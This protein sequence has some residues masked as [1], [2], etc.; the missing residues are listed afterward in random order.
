MY[1]VFRKFH[2]LFIVSMTENYSNLNPERGSNAI[3]FILGPFRFENCLEAPKFIKAFLVG[4]F[5]MSM[6][7]GAIPQHKK[8]YSTLQ[9]SRQDILMM[10]RSPFSRP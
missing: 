6:Y 3:M 10:G 9:F 5:L 7:V 1:G 8:S 4:V 2:H